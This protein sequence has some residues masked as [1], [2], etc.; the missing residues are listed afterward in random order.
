ML[1]TRG[2]GRVSRNAFMGAYQSRPIVPSSALIDVTLDEVGSQIQRHML[3]NAT[4]HVKVSENGAP[5]VPVAR[6]GE[7]GL[8]N[9][10]NTC[11]LNSVLQC[12]AHTPMLRQHLLLGKQR[13]LDGRPTPLCDALAALF[14]SMYDGQVPPATITAVRAAINQRTNDFFAGIAQHD[15]QELMMAVLDGLHEEMNGAAKS[16][17]WSELPDQPLRPDADLAAEWWGAHIRRNRSPIVDCSS[18]YC[19]T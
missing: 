17:Q 6:R 18:C 3:Q 2:A 13:D 8:A 4:L 1:D 16:I 7:C 19:G 12:L 15:A 9:L 14:R 11:Y 10:G 5:V